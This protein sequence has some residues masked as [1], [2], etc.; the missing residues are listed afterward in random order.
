MP[1]CLI[2]RVVVDNNND[3]AAGDAF[4][5]NSSFDFDVYVDIEVKVINF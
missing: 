5:V 3:D 4:D 2:L 1:N